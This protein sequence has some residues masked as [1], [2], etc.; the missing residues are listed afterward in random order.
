MVKLFNK[1]VFILAVFG[2]SNGQD[3]CPDGGWG[4]LLRKDGDPVYEDKGVVEK[5]SV[6]GQLVTVTDD[7]SGQTSSEEDELD[8]DSSADGLSIYRV[9]NGSR[10]V[11]WNYDI[12]GFNGGR[13][14]EITDLIATKGFTV[15]I[16]DYYRGETAEKHFMTGTLPKFI[17][18]QT[19]WENLK[20][21]WEEGVLPYAEDHGCKTFGA[22]G[23]CW[24]SYMV[25]R[26][27][28]DPKM[29]AGVSMHPSHSPIMA[30]HLGEDEEEILNEIQDDSR[31]V[32][33]P[34]AQDH[35]NVKPGGLGEAVL[36][37]RLQIVEFP[38]MR[39]GWTIRGNLTVPEVKRDVAKAIEL[40]I[41][42][43]EKYL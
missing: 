4:E 37:D 42:H 31:Q 20:R 41:E 27:A 12:F 36:G 10:C 19:V 34:S 29:K 30:T 11:I 22:I 32:F 17:K 38:E 14:R 25:V 39:H 28:A 18:Q 43:F 33:M 16:P 40:A 2:A 7:Q 15:L 5:V 9:G 21:D 24:G 35:V 26:L 3:C 1:I 8:G 23:T 6:S 13:T